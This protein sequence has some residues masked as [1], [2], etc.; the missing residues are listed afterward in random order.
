[1]NRRVRNRTHGG[2]GGRR[3]KFR[4]LPDKCAFKPCRTVLQA[5][6]WLVVLQVDFLKIAE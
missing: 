6:T 4:L 3:K 5:V 2:V 1:M